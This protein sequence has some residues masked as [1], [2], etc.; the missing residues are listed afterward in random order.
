MKVLIVNA[1]PRKGGNCEILCDRFAKGAK[2][3]GHDVETIAVRTKK[4]ANCLA[5][6]ACKRNGGTCVQK[7]DMA[8]VFRSMMEADVLVFASPVYFYSIAAQM[9]QVIDRSYVNYTALTNKKLYY[10]VT[11]ADPQHATAET[12]LLD[13][14]G[15]ARCLPESEEK[16]TVYGTGAWAKG[17]VE[18]ISAFNEAYEMG[19]SV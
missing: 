12:L 11:S 13:L 4:I 19:K 9:K 3:A 7:D 16:G 8:D 2:E 14:H 5:C 1:S 6:D 17:D 18:K 15:F 10:I